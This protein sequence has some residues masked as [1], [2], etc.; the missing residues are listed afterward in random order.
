MNKTPENFSIIKISFFC[1][2]ENLP[3]HMNTKS[4]RCTSIVKRHVEVHSGNKH[5]KCTQC[6]KSFNRSS[7][8]KRHLKIHSSEKPYKCTQCKKCFNQ[9]SNL[10]THVRIH[11]GDKP[12]KCDQCH[13][14]FKCNKTLKRHRCSGRSAE[15]REIFT[16]W[17][18]GEYCHNVCGILFHMSEHGMR[19]S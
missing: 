11:S 14:C 6:K 1:I 5:I 4:N 13:K 15:D 7:T 12:I 18:C 17:M 2:S 16:C 8:L 19:K 9:S 3:S 10:K